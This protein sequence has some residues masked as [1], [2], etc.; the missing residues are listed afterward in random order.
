MKLAAH[1]NRTNILITVTLLIIGAVIYFLAINYIARSQLDNDLSE[2]VAEVIDYVSANHKLPK[3]VD[4]DEDQTVFIETNQKQI[5]PRFFD[6]VYVNP[7]EKEKKPGRAIESIIQLNGSYYKVIITVSRES[8]EYLLQFVGIITL[9]LMVGLLLT[10]FLANRYFL[11]GL[12]KPF[13]ALL[14][15]IKEFNISEK[16]NFKLTGERVDEFVELS[17]AI[18]DMSKRVSNDYQN[19]KHLTDNASHEMLTPLAVIT[20]KLD[21]LIQHERLPAEI[22]EQIEDIYSATS[23]LS[24][25]NQ[26]LLL[27]TKIEN[28]LII[29]NEPIDLDILL[30]D[31]IKQFQELILAKQISVTENLRKKEVL[32]SKYLVDILL[33]NLIS[34]AIWHNNDYGDLIITLDDEELLFQNTGSPVAL[35]REH[36]FERFKKGNKSEGTGLGLTLVENI[37][38]FCGWEISYN[39]KENLHSFKIVF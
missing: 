32:V 31:K 28:N 6:T 11:S 15:Q 33:N 35:N 16:N 22:Y 36:V 25:M 5:Q 9:G 13:Y 23:K 39:F 24:R 1:Y 18:D 14:H 37:C 7:K 29:G 30:T 2:E 17:A 38:K 27:L 34:N 19:L 21:I 20:A 26:T 4:F 3:Q 8:T 10:L 12:W